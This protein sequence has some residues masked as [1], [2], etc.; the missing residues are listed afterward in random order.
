VLAIRS[1]PPCTN[2]ASVRFCVD[3]GSSTHAVT[4]LRLLNDISSDKKFAGETITGESVNMHTRGSLQII[5]NDH[6]DITITNVYYDP[7]LQ[8]SALSVGRLCAAGCR[9]VF[10]GDGGYVEHKGRTLFHL[11]REEFTYWANVELPDDSSAAPISYAQPLQ[12][13]S[14]HVGACDRLNASAKLSPNCVRG[15]V[16]RPLTRAT[17]KPSYADV[18]RKCASLS[19]PSATKKPPQRKG[20]PRMAQTSKRSCWVPS[21]PKTGEAVQSTHPGAPHCCP[22]VPANEGECRAGW[23]SG[24]CPVQQSHTASLHCAC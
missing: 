9:A 24:H 13:T 7:K 17:A 3:S 8:F 12:T 1:I 4:R 18:L 6:E 22:P 14:A 2:S 10:E 21:L 19:N 23:R 20:E 15:S 5:G 11:Q 16:A